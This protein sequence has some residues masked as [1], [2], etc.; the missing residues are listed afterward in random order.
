M[1]HCSKCL[2]YVNLFDF[3]K[4]HFTDDEYQGTERLNYLHNIM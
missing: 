2:T 1:G 4:A 3:Q